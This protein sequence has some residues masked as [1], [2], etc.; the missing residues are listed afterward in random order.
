MRELINEFESKKLEHEVFN[1]ELVPCHI[2]HTET[3]KL[4]DT[5]DIHTDGKRS[6]EDIFLFP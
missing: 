5:Y 3:T 2:C 6:A 1:R 4:Y